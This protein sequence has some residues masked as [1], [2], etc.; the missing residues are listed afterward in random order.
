MTEESVHL[1]FASRVARN[2]AFLVLACTLACG[3]TPPPSAKV[4]PSEHTGAERP[5]YGAHLSARTAVKKIGSIHTPQPLVSES[6]DTLRALTPSPERRARIYERRH[7]VWA[8]PSNADRLVPPIRGATFD[9]TLGQTMVNILAGLPEERRAFGLGALTQNQLYGNCEDPQILATAEHEGETYE[10]RYR[11]EK[12]TWLSEPRPAL[13]AL[14]STC[15]GALLTSGGDVASVIGTACSREDEEAHFAP[16]TGCRSCLEVDG[17]HTRCVAATRCKAE[18]AREMAYGIG[19]QRFYFDVMEAVALACAPDITTEIIILANELGEDNEPVRAFDHQGIG[20]YCQWFWNGSE[21]QLY[22]DS[23]VPGVNIAMSDVL[24]GWVEYIRKPGD[25][26]TPY[27]DRMALAASAEVEGM[28]LGMTPLY[29]GTLAE[30]SV[31][32]MVGGGW[33]MNPQVLR[34]GET[35]PTDINATYA[36]DWVA[37]VGLKT[38]TN[39]SFVPIVIYNRNLCED[40]LWR[41]PDDKGRFFCEQ[42][43]FSEENPPPE[44]TRWNYDWSRFW[45]QQEPAIIEPYPLI[46]LA[47]T[48]MPDPSVPGG[49]LPHILGSPV[50]ADEDWENCAW[51]EMFEPDEQR[52]FDAPIEDIYSFTGQ[53]YRFGKDPRLDIRMVLATNTRR[54]FCFEPHTD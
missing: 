45:I 29:P 1:Y 42:P 10:L 25:P 39:I 24:G 16:S 26:R 46:T 52:V 3:E 37:A 14:S 28:Q 20:H 30:V 19:N 47:S 32:E 44:P 15:T 21:P 7:S 41:G 51:P 33:G 50:L 54:Q 43:V 12:L 48:G 8:T 36:R 40:S 49:A 6:Y 27:L 53:T 22:C 13:Y 11:P 17:D 35:D 38:A 4:E 31:P 18:M 23:G 2:S 5:P 9:H 34:P